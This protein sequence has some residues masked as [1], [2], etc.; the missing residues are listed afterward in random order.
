SRL[1]RGEAA[2]LQLNSSEAL[3]ASGYPPVLR[4]LGA[5]HA[6]ATYCGLG[7]L[8]PEL[9]TK[10]T[11]LINSI[12]DLSTE[13]AKGD[14]PFARDRALEL[15]L[16]PQ[17]A[18]QLGLADREAGYRKVEQ[19]LTAAKADQ[20]LLLR[21]KGSF[22]VRSAWDARGDGIAITVTPEGWKLFTQRLEQADEA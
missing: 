19:A 3:H 22:L 7:K 8:P 9:K 4:A 2:A 1:K 15:L 11:G 20:A 21:L 17:P 16:V 18:Y 6:A 13:V 14:D 10:V 12:W 5:H